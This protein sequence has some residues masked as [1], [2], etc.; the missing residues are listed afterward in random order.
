MSEKS[1]ENGIGVVIGSVIVLVLLMPLV[2]LITMFHTFVI[3]TL[4]G[5]FLV[6]L[7]CTAIKF[8]NMYGIMLFVNLFTYQKFIPKDKD[9]KVQTLYVFALPT[10][11]LLVGWIV[12]SFLM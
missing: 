9:D 11:S 10:I 12:K 7:G 6:P 1:E 2:I 8:W 5:W 3:S 4:Y